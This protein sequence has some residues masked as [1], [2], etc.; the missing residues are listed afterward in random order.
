MSKN[1]TFYIVTIATIL[2]IFAIFYT[3]FKLIKYKSF[4]D[5]K[6]YLGNNDISYMECR[7]SINHI[8][9]FAYKKEDKKRA[10]LDYYYWYFSPWGNIVHE[11]TPD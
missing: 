5:I 1:K 2:G 6:E 9:I 10:S 8:L 7:T 11:S 3:S 4:I